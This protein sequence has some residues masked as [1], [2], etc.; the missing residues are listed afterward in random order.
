[1]V[2]I[3]V[4]VVIF[5]ISLAGLSFVTV[6]NTEYKAVQVDG[7]LLQLEQIAGSGEEFLKL[8]LDRPRRD[9]D[10]A[11]GTWD[12]P[13]Q[14]RDVPACDDPRVRRRGRFTV[15]SPRTGEDSSGGVR[16]GLEN[17]SGRLNLSVL[18]AWDAERPGQGREALM[19][20]PGMTESTADA[21]LDWIDPDSN[22]RQFGAEAD[23]YQGIGVPYAP[24]NGVPQCLEELL[25]IRGVS[26]DLLLGPAS[27]AN[28]PPADGT[29]PIAAAHRSMGM[30][31]SGVPWASLLSVES[32][33]RNR[34][35]AGE[36]RINVND[37][38][39]AGLYNRLAQRFDPAWARFLLAYR[40]L[41]P[42]VGTETP[43]SAASLPLDL[44][45]PARFPIVSV[46]DLVGA[47][48]RIPSPN[49][50][51]AKIVA[52]PLAATTAAMRGYLPALLDGTTTSADP[53]LRGR[54]NVNTASRTV[55]RAIPGL[56]GAAVEQILAAR[57]GH[58]SGDPIWRTAAWLLTEGIVDLPK[59]RKLEPYLT[60]AGDVYRAQLIGYYEDGGPSTR[61]EVVIDAANSPPRLVY[62]KDLPLPGP[63]YPRETLGTGR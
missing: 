19:K 37:P 22:P 44:S 40:Q 3:I 31:P 17:E 29:S 15:L 61:A 16:F 12:N 52:S 51:S 45:S 35:Y 57:R 28:G 50:K 7:D 39:L 38:N 9:Q 27:Q 42:Y 24:R 41:G 54:I 46:L 14:F 56:E 4:I 5:M 55:L 30:E 23:Y 53:V 58:D 8:F 11:G 36:P 1:M 48:I 49:S 10:Q 63:A 13:G 60:A 26:R 21:I 43:D 6:M 32:A 25:L 33:E 62:Y 20:L 18:L 47:K 2:L 59:M 34:S